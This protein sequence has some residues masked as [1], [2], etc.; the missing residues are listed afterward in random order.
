MEHWSLR[1]NLVTAP[2]GPRPNGVVAGLCHSL[3]CRFGLRTFNAPER[4]AATRTTITVMPSFCFAVP[5][6]WMLRHSGVPAAYLTSAFLR[7]SSVL[8][9]RGINKLRGISPHWEFDSHPGHH[10]HS[11]QST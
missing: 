9:F 11:K 10:L 2:A 5:T 7:F 8:V 6:N 3:H 1:A 4:H